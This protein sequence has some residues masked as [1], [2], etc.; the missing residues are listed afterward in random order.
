MFC[1]TAVQSGRGFGSVLLGLSRNV[2]LPVASTVGQSLVRKGLKT[3]SGVLSGV[4]E[5][6]GL[7]RAL[8]NATETTRAQPLRSRKQRKIAKVNNRSKKDQIKKT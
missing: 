5:G 1:G 3:A 7:K 4:A 8:M 6:K 2:V